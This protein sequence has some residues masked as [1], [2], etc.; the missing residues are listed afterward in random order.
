[1]LRRISDPDFPFLADLRSIATA[2]DKKITQ[3]EKEVN[4]LEKRIM[5]IEIKPN[6]AEIEA[7]NEAKVCAACAILQERI[8]IAQEAMDP[9]FD[10]SVWDV[11]SWRQTLL[12]LGGD[13]EVEQVKALEASTSGVKDVKDGGEGGAGAAEGDA[14]E[15]GNEG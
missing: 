11:A 4:S 7:T 15:V 13:A 9:D 14:A 2:K 3:L 6:K 12:E 8:N 10:R 1:M 5:V